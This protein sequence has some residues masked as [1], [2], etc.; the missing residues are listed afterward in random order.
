MQLQ[1]GSLA[2]MGGGSTAWIRHEALASISDLLFADLAAPTP[3]NEAEWEASQ[4]TWSESFSM[5]LLAL[6]AQ[7]G[8]RLEP[9]ERAAL[10]RHQALTS[11]RLRPTRDADGFRRQLIVATKAGKVAALHTGDGGLLWEVDFGAEAAP[12]RLAAWLKPHDM[13]RDEEVVAFRADDAGVVATVINIH[14]GLVVSSDVVAASAG[15]EVLPMPHPVRRDSADQHVYLV[16]PAQGP[17]T[18]LPRIAEAQAAFAAGAHA[19]VQWGVD[20][21]AGTV[22]GF[23]FGADGSRTVRWSMVAAP[24]GSGLSV[25]AVAARDAAEAVYG[26]ARP[27]A[28]GAILLKYLSPNTLLVLAGPPL[29]LDHA[30]ASRLVATLLDAASGRVLFTQTHQVRTNSLTCLGIHCFGLHCTL[31]G[32]AHFWQPAK[33]PQKAKALGM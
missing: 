32:V 24:A 29:G 11:D 3:E 6:R 2:L 8:L 18:V 25:L 13:R 4:P 9:Q 15:A 27:I 19:L 1:E 20:Q 10:A 17:A 14:T 30:K 28:G 12:Q 31:W 16:V 22:H 33:A 21:A 26:A 7:A 23:G 5:Q